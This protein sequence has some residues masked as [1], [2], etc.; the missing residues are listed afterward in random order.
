MSK[1]AGILIRTADL[2]RSVDFYINALGQRLEWQRGDAA[3]IAPRAG[4]LL[5]IAGPEAGDLSPWLPQAYDQPVPGKRVY[6]GGGTPAF[7]AELEQKGVPVLHW[8]ER[9]WGSTLLLVEDPDGHIVSFTA[10]KPWSD[11]EMLQ[12]YQAA[13][14]RLARALEGLSEADLDLARAPGKWTIRQLVLHIV[15]SDCTSLVRPKF[16]LAEPGRAFNVNA[17]NPDAW[18]DGLDYAHRP[19]S[20]EVALFGAIRA[21]MAGLLTHLPGAL[22]RTTVGPDG[23]A[24][25]VRPSIYALTWHALHHIDQIFDTR[26]VH[27]R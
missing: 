17:Y 27:G 6:W 3:L 21:H 5:L 13:P 16:A 26:R 20:A 22:D 4:R 7:K 14:A 25:P 2:A 12:W 23:T 24:T 1:Q 18:A 8:E 15:D 9:D 10:G 11:G 19:V